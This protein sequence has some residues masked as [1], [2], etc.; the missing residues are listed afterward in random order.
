MELDRSILG[1]E[2]TL[3]QYAEGLQNAHSARAVVVS[4]WRRQQRE[5]VV[6]RVLVRADDGDGRREVANLGL[7]A[8]NDRRLREAMGEVFEGYVGVEG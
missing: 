5:D 7:E 6:G 2:A 4:S 3:G 8:S 1:D